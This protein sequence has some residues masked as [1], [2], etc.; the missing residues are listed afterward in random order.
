MRLNTVA[1]IVMGLFFTVNTATAEKKLFSTSNNNTASTEPSRASDPS[2]K[3]TQKTNGVKGVKFNPTPEVRPIDADNVG[4]SA[5]APETTA[6][7][8][9]LKQ[10]GSTDLA[11][12]I[13]RLKEE[14]AFDLDDILGAGAEIPV[15]NF[16]TLLAHDTITNK[17]VI[18]IVADM[19]NDNKQ[20]LYALLSPSEG[21]ALK[22]FMDDY[23]Q[24]FPNNSKLQSTASLEVDAQLQ[25]PDLP[26]TQKDW[27]ERAAIANDHLVRFQYDRDLVENNPDIKLSSDQK[28]LKTT[29]NEFITS[30]N[31][32]GTLLEMVGPEPTAKGYATIKIV[33][34]LESTYQTYEK[35]FTAIASGQR[36]GLSGLKTLDKMLITL[37]SLFGSRKNVVLNAISPEIKQAID[38][39]AL[40]EALQTGKASVLDLNHASSDMIK[41][42]DATQ[43]NRILE[44]NKSTTGERPSLGSSVLN[45]LSEETL[46]GVAENLTPEEKAKLISAQRNSIL[47]R[48][49]DFAAL[50]D[51]HSYVNSRQ[52]DEHGAPREPKRPLVDTEAPHQSPHPIEEEMR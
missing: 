26:K 49:S 14:N 7:Q 42:L 33:A 21:A 27:L 5:K 48:R 3:K 17:R 38:N 52:R 23:N 22:S 31:K 36:Q 28:M 20:F 46:R 32:A 45:N 15:I 41:L 2:Q 39:I 9:W 6:E 10:T 12:A 4:R 40:I 11:K 19:Q 37:K 34:S 47:D 51:H 24:R 18:A 16:N 35:T 8:K 43:V 29:W 25:T 30:M 13:N 44:S 1:A 50:H